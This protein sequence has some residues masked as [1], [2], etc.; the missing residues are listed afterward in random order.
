MPFVWTE[1]SMVPD[2]SLIG[3]ARRITVAVGPV[4]FDG[5]RV[6][7][8][9]IGVAIPAENILAPN[10]YYLSGTG[11]LVVTVALGPAGVVPS[12]LE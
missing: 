9:L 1:F 7:V 8:I 11:W 12:S 5:C 3:E 4:I 10:R 6:N 2:H